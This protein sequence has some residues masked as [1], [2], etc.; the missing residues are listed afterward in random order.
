MTNTSFGGE[1]KR[2]LDVLAEHPLGLNI[3]EIAAAV[4]MS[5]NSVAKYLDVLTASGHLE[6]RS[7]GNAK[8]YYL[9]RRVPIASIMNMHREMIVILDRDL[10][11]VQASDSFAVFNGCER[12]DI[13][14]TKLNRLP[15]PLGPDIDEAELLASLHGGPVHNKEFRITKNGDDRIITARF[16]PTT[17]EDGGFGI[18]L[19]LEDITERRLAEER[20]KENERLLQTIFQISPVAYFMINRNHNVV[21]WNR[22]M[23]LMTGIKAEEITGTSQHWKAFYPKE[24]PCLA[25]LL[26]DN[27]RPAL[28]RMYRDKH[29]KKMNNDSSYEYFD[30]FPGIGKGGKW[31]HLTARIVRDSSGNPLGVLQTLEDITDKKTSEPQGKRS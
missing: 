5:R 12:R 2:I 27:D 20:V 1:V 7:M 6:V 14:G 3:K 26:I 28:D 13:L 23:E 16:N 11:I 24:H 19:Q 29:L 30:F 4:A 9:S 21:S 22:V 8:M 31:L 18:A 15:V 25:D 17:F 10:R